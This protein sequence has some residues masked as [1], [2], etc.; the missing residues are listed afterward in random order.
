M[1]GLEV[2]THVSARHD[3][4]PACT[5]LLLGWDTFHRPYAGYEPNARVVGRQ[6]PRPNSQ[7]GKTYSRE[8]C[9]LPTVTHIIPHTPGLLDVSLPCVYSKALSWL[10]TYFHCATF[11]THL[12][13]AQAGPKPAAGFSCFDRH[14]MFKRKRSGWAWAE[15]DRSMLRDWNNTSQSSSS[16][17]KRLLT[18]RSI[19]FCFFHYDHLFVSPCRN[20]NTV[21]VA[22]LK[23]NEKEAKLLTKLR[24][25]RCCSLHIWASV[26][27]EITRLNRDA[28]IFCRVVHANAW[29]ICRFR[30]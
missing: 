11:R 29:N 26:C 17:S 16:V 3:A 30:A 13:S 28:S 5:P 19:D 10:V 14:R 21:I 15:I 27:V 20:R 12:P 25:L 4:R 2:A 8:V 18:H 23:D 24:R 9:R 22:H 7:E 6:N 1:A